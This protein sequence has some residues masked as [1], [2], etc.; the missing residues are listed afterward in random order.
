[1]YKNKDKNIY[2]KTTQKKN[3]INNIKQKQHKHIQ[4]KRK[5]HIYIY[6]YIYK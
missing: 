6:I 1:M 5:K 4:T 3:K 2:R